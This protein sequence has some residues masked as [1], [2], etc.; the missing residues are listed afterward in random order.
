MSKDKNIF[1]KAKPIRK[2]PCPICRRHG[3]DKSGDNLVVYENGG[4]YCFVCEKTIS[5]SDEYREKLRI[6]EE[7]EKEI[8]FPVTDFKKEDWDKLKA[9]L[10]TDPKGFR[11]LKKSTCDVFRVYHDFDQQTGEVTTQYYPISKQN[12]FSGIKVRKNPKAFR[13]EG[14]NDS[15]CDLFGQA[16]FAKSTSKMILVAAG[17][18][19][20]LSAFQML[21]SNRKPD[22][23]S[24]PVVSGT[25]GEV[26][27][28]NQYKTNYEF[29]DRFEKIIFIPD[30][31]EAGERALE[32]VAK[33][34]PRDKL[35]I[36]DLPAKDPNKMLEDGRVKEFI[37]AFWKHRHY[38]PAGISGSDVI[39]DQILEKALVAK[40]P[41]PPFLNKLNEVTGGG[42]VKGSIIN[43][44]AGCYP[45][46]TEFF[47]GTQWKSIADYK[48]GESVLQYNKDTCEAFLA[49]PKEYIVL[50][51]DQFY[52]IKNKRIS[53]TTSAAHKHLIESE[54]GVIS[55]ITTMSLVANH[56]E[57]ARGNKSKLLNTFSYSGSGV[58][59]S[60]EY[61]RL[62]VAVFADS[63]FKKDSESSQA[64]VRLKKDRKIL[65]LH[66]LLKEAGINYSVKS[67]DNGYTIFKFKMDNRDKHFPTSWYNLSKAQLSVVVDEVVHWDGSLVDRT[68]TDRKPTWSFT[69]LCK[70]D[71]DFIQF[72]LTSLGKSASLDFD[73]REK[74]KNE[75]KTAYNVR[76]VGSTGYGI[77][78]D[79]SKEST[80]TIE[81]VEQGNLMYCFTT[82][83]G[84]FPVRQN[85]K[86]FVSGNSGSGKTTLVNEIVLDMIQNRTAKVGVVSLEADAGDYGE[87]LLGAYIQKKL[88]LIQSPEEKFEFIASD[89][90]KKAAAEL[91]KLEDGKPSFHI[92]DERGDY[93]NLQPKI[94]ELIITC[95]A[96]VIVVD[97]LSDVFDG[98][99]LDFQAKWMAWEK[100]ICKRYGVIFINVIHSRKASGGQKSASTGAVLTEEDM[101]GSGSQYKS[102]SLNIIL[103]RD[104]TA[105]DENIR[106]MIQVH[107]TKN[108][109]TGWTGC[110]CYLMYNMQTHKLAD[111]SDVF[112]AKKEEVLKNGLD[113]K[114]PR[115]QQ[116]TPLNRF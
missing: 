18:L 102:A 84:Y 51:V 25:I 86:I 63:H 80:T 87:N 5:L 7:E 52:E 24:I 2:E 3:R 29:L 10:V 6:K 76:M 101:I 38:S 13:A 42:M 26:G 79:T 85:G 50:P 55:T 91:F 45:A 106:N 33:S 96:E 72:A 70:D 77:S 82:E 113:N 88:Q 56:N 22:F 62:K 114:Q 107:L 116:D 89:P 110:A 37:S 78:K 71:A 8:V 1:N 92:I 39:Y 12:A 59:I 98:A 75:S 35:Y 43:I 90:V 54:N 61:L 74:Y 47:N 109:Q 97:V 60:D 64:I 81:P 41:F 53:F 111:A 15:S 46:S 108:R 30:Q 112:E 11:G 36:V 34:L 14:T 100:A 27:S 21:E 57:K 58:D 65:R 73:P 67:D 32:K 69:T 19:D 16:V 95:D 49:K 99:T 66:S 83:T 4:K 105:E 28:I 40:I 31:D 103:S 68:G 23:P 104:K 9:N 48:E 17:E 94:E 93:E 20:A 44:S 115:Q